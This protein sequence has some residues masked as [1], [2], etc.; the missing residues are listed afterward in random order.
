MTPEGEREVLQRLAKLDRRLAVITVI[1]FFTLALAGSYFAY[2][3]AE[4]GWGFASIWT[5][6]VAL[7]V[8]LAIVRLLTLEAAGGPK[9]NSH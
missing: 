7:A 8:L 1:A 9:S 5:L 6:G 4:H 2:R 3:E